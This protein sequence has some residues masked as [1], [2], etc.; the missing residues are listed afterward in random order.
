MIQITNKY[1]VKVDESTY[2]AV[3]K[4]VNHENGKVTYT[5]L[6]YLSSFSKAVE[7]IMRLEQADK[8]NE[9]DMTLFEAIEELKKI[10]DDFKNMM[11]LYL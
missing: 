4:K 5:P 10:N 6:H 8:L 3:M 1:Y 11:E 7:Q 2:I 9:R